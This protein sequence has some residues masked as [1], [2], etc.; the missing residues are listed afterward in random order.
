MIKL[1]FSRKTNEVPLDRPSVV[2]AAYCAA[3]Q[4]RRRDT[5]EGLDEK[6]F[7]AALDLAL[8]R[9]QAM[10]TVGEGRI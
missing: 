6:R 3:E 5:A 8:E 4:E 10:E 1:P 7:Q 9:L 2:F